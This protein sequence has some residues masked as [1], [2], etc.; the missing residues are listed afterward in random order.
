MS[1]QTAV[2]RAESGEGPSGRER[3]LSEER[4][5]EPFFPE[6]H[7]EGALEETP[8]LFTA[9]VPPLAAHE[10]RFE[11][12]ALTHAWLALVAAGIDDVHARVSRAAAPA[13]THFRH[14]GAAPRAPET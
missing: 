13:S 9:Q 14:A 1:T 12:A 3:V 7:R 11:F 2:R 6:F 5:L 10:V 8:A 4:L